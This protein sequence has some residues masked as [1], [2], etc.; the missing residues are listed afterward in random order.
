[1]SA[2]LLSAQLERN[3]FSSAPNGA[4]TAHDPSSAQSPH[5][6]PHSIRPWEPRRQF[7]QHK[8]FF[9]HSWLIFRNFFGIFSAKHIG[10]E[11]VAAID[12][13]N[14][15]KICATKTLARFGGNRFRL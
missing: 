1:M 8:N 10:G 15:K 6:T 9:S 14:F 7:C 3:F 11:D 4:A 12:I 13:V 5:S 2:L